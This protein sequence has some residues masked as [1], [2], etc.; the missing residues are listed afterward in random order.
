MGKVSEKIARYRSILRGILEQHANDYGPGEEA[1]DKIIVDTEH[2][3]FQLARIGWY[4]GRRL[5][6][7]ILHFDIKP[8]GKIWLQTNWTEEQITDELLRMGVPREDIVLG[9]HPPEYRPYTEFAVA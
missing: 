8:D 6:S 5:E 9:M 7:I 4:K 2:N 3:Y 1:E